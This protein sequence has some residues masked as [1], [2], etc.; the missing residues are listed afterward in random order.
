MVVYWTC[1][2]D[3]WM[4]SSCREMFESPSEIFWIC[5]SSFKKINKD[6]RIGMKHRF[7][8]S[9]AGND[10]LNYTNYT[11]SIIEQTWSSWNHRKHGVFKTLIYALST[12]LKLWSGQTIFFFFF[13]FWMKIYFWTLKLISFHLLETY[14]VM[15]MLLIL[16]MIEVFCQKFCDNNI[17]GYFKANSCLKQIV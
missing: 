17:Y 1:E 10:D 8:L 14:I 5:L 11:P 4:H 15:L 2:S 3:L 7:Y 6:K 16:G 13:H 9:F 12:N